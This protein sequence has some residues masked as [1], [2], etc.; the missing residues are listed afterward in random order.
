MRNETTNRLLISAACVLG[1]AVFLIDALTTLDFA[2]AVLYVLVILM[3]ALTGSIPATRLAGGASAVLTLTAF[4]VAP[5][6]MDDQ[7]HLVRCLFALLA[8]CT[9]TLLAL[10]MLADMAQ[11]RVAEAALARSEA[12]LAEA[13]KL[14]KTGSIF[15]RFPEGAMAW[16]TESYRI[17]G[18]PSTEE[19][20]LNRIMPRVHPDDLAEVQRTHA[21]ML[22]GAPLIELKHRLRMPNDDV[23]HVHLVA[24]RTVSEG[25][26]HEYVGALMDVTETV[27]T[28]QALQG[29]MAELA[30]AARVATLGQLAASIAH[31]VTQPMAAVIAC[32]NSALRWLRRPQ[33]NIEEAADSV[34]QIVRD[35]SRA[36]E[37]IQRIR[38]MARKSTPKYEQIDVNRLVVGALEVVRRELQDHRV[39]ADIDLAAESATIRGDWT[40]LQQVLVNLM[41]NAVQA[42]TAI[43]GRRRLTV[44]SR[45]TPDNAVTVIVSDTGPGISPEHMARLFHAFHTT[46][47]NGMGLGL[48]ICRG[49]VE[50]HGGTIEAESP[51]GSGA[52]L[53]VR[54][55]LSTG[56]NAQPMAVVPSDVPIEKSGAKS[57]ERP[58]SDAE[59]PG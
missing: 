39:A 22:G 48:S 25:D 38:A 50:R 36:T 28:Q 4:G 30:H 41:V 10:R 1:L 19:A 20:H 33:P 51:P 23:L 52:T 15:I 12:F 7:G 5:A 43:P 32:G 54:L 11:R 31:E 21:A 16:S 29:T 6:H 27:R 24:R 14:S 59:R 2:I 45:I 17:F 34:E 40:Q 42:M 44:S 56:E 55:P 47:S 3:V 26:R 53:I 35:A 46:K 9:T 37:I 57:H 49:I 8:I 13:Q 18:Y 58:T